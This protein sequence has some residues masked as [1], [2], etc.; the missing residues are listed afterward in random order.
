MPVVLALVMTLLWIL[1]GKDPP[2]KAVFPRFAPPQGI[3]A[4]FSRYVWSM[5]MDDQAFAAMVLGMAVKGP[6]TIEER[7]LVAEAAKQTG[8]DASQASMG[9]KLLK[10]VGK[11]MFF[12]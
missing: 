1:W 3:E 2:A 8:K 6:L 4:G 5:R 11:P 10:L 9:M 7:S 12:A